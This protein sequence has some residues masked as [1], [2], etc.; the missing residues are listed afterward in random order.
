MERRTRTA[1]EGHDD[2][3]HDID[4]VTRLAGELGGV[5]GDG[6]REA[7]LLEIATAALRGLSRIRNRQPQKIGF[8][9][10]PKIRADRRDVERDR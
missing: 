8:C 7:V 3:R 6:G 2:A 4:E 9:P 1:V 5:S 10:P